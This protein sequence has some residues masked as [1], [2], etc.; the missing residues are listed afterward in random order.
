MARVPEIDTPCP[1]S[2]AEQLL[3]DG[4]CG[5]CNKDVH[6][7]DGLGDAE[8]RQLLAA[9][10]G[11]LCVSY[12]LPANRSPAL[13]VAM[14]AMLSTGA[15]MAGQDCDEVKS[16]FQSIDSSP[17][18]QV[19]SNEPESERLDTI[20]MVG[21]IESAED[22][23]W[24]DDSGLPELPIVVETESGVPVDQAKLSVV[25]KRR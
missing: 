6:V 13:G 16:E 12:R 25:P 2:R 14:A 20:I 23:T 9:T 10:K 17:S 19:L 8:R 21:G 18:S 3:I 4:H 22:A 24:I 11:P 7:L 1:L 5:R 15:A